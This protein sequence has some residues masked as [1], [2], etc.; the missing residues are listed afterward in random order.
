[1]VD[2]KT[3]TP[4]IEYSKV[5]FL[6]FKDLF[7]I[8]VLYIDLRVIVI[9]LKAMLL[10]VDQDLSVNEVYLKFSKSTF[11]IPYSIHFSLHNIILCKYFYRIFYLPRS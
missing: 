3:V 6:T 5:K 4:K 8:K 2:F 10:S 7:E 11:K 9:L 1:M